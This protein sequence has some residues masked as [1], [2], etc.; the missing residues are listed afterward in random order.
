MSQRRIGTDG[1]FFVNENEI[2]V[3]GKD[4]KER[5]LDQIRQHEEARRSLKAIR[6]IA[7]RIKTIAAITLGVVCLLRLFE[8]LP[9]TTCAY[10]FGMCNAFILMSLVV[11]RKYT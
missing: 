10:A 11:N 7:N 1:C 8:I 3:S 6:R 5:F 9:D 2:S 4:N